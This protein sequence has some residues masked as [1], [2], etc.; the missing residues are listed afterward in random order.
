M[1]KGR[2]GL[3]NLKKIKIMATKQQ[4]EM[5]A[6]KY[7]R[8][9]REEKENENP[10]W[11]MIDFWSTKARLQEQNAATAIDENDIEETREWDTDYSRKYF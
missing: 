8:K 10:D 7:R 11:D 3:L 5:E 4:Y 6:A 2:P 1:V 9:V